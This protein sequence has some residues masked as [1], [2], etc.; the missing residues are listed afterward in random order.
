MLTATLIPNS[1]SQ[2]RDP[3][4]KAK[5]LFFSKKATKNI[6]T[7]VHTSV[8]SDIVFDIFSLIIIIEAMLRVGLRRVTSL[9][10]INKKRNTKKLEELFG[11][12]E[13]A[14]PSV[15]LAA[16]KQRSQRVRQEAS[17]RQKVNNYYNYE[18]FRGEDFI[19]NVPYAHGIKY[20]ARD[21]LAEQEEK[22][23]LSVEELAPL[24]NHAER[25]KLIRE[26][27][28]AYHD[29]Q[30]KYEMQEFE[31]YL[32]QYP[33]TVRGPKPEDDWQAYRAYA[34]KKMPKTLQD[35]LSFDQKDAIIREEFDKEDDLNETIGATIEAPSSMLSSLGRDRILLDAEK[36]SKEEQ[37][38][39]FQEFDQG[40]EYQQMTGGEH[41][42]VPMLPSVK[43]E[44]YQHYINHI[45]DWLN[46]R[47]SYVKHN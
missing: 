16:N 29:K 46:F 5:N 24:T 7:G 47:N 15:L 44:N 28:N 13:T 39:W 22:E 32:S 17:H 12:G 35:E 34:M 43:Y 27:I 6:C 31:K 11:S 25:A 21:K 38:A 41:L 40:Y 3:L 36:T 10:S 42:D 33:G 8:K 20:T 37:N 2:L 18:Y 4:S 26:K 19:E 1:C 14:S 45:Q 9:F 23:R 30:K